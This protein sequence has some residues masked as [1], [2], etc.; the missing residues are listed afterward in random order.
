MSLFDC[1]GRRVETEVKIMVDR[2]ES[3]PRPVERQ[4]SVSGGAASVVGNGG[5]F[6]SSPLVGT[7]SGPIPSPGPAST[8][9][10]PIVKI[11]HYVLGQTLGTG[12]FGKVKSIFRIHF[13]FLM[14]RIF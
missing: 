7:P 1:F 3:I 12:T 2:R 14:C 10:Q 9:Q 13:Y 6:S 8:N 4:R 11:G 5:D